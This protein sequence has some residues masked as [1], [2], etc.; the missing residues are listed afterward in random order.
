MKSTCK[1]LK[2]VLDEFSYICL[3]IRIGCGIC[4]DS[5]GLGIWH[6]YHALCS[7]LRRKNM[8]GEVI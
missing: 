5:I 2:G 7:I 6:K 4:D 1:V 3:G 8:I